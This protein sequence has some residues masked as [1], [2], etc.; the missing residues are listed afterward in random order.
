MRRV[1]KRAAAG[2]VWLVVCGVAGAETWDGGG[3]DNEYSTALNWNNDVI[4]TNSTGDINGAYTVERFADI[5][6]L[7]TFVQGGAILNVTGGTQNDSESGNTIRNFIGFGSKGT[8]NQSGGSYNIGHILIVGGSNS[9]GDGTY[10][11]SGGDLAVSRGG[12]SFMGVSGGSSIE[13][14]VGGGTGLFNI[15]GGSL[16]TRIGVGIGATGTFRVQGSGA[17]IIGIGSNGSLDGDW[18][19]SA[20]GTLSVG[21]DAGGVTKILIDDYQDDGGAY[22]TFESGSLLD[23]DFYSTGSG[24]GTWTVLEVEGTN[25]VDN[26]LAFAPGVDTSVWSFAIDNSGPNGLLTVTSVGESQNPTHV[27]VN[28]IAQLQQYADASNMTV[29]MTPGTY[30]L[31]GPSIRPAPYANYAVFLDLSGANST[32][33]F[34]GVHIKVDTQELDGYGR[35]YGH[36]SGVQVLQISGY[37]VEVDGLTLTMEKVSYDGVDQYGNPRE[38]SADW[39]SQLVRVIASNTTIKNCNFTTGGSYPYGYGDAFGKGNRPNTDGVTDAAWISHSKQSGFL[40]T[41]GASNVTVDNVVLNMRSFGHGFFMQQGAGN[42]LFKDCKA[43]G[44][45]MADSDD[46]IA[47]PEY[48]AWGFATYKEP[49]PADIRISKHEDAFRTYGNSDSANNGYPAD[50]YNVTITNCVA[51]RMRN[52]TP[53]HATGYCRIYD[54]EVYDCEMGLTANS[55]GESTILNCKGNARNGPLIY[56]QYS[57]VQPAIYEVELTGD[58]P[59]HGVK[60]IALISGAGNRITLT[61]SAAPGVYSKEAYLN[62]SQKWREWRHRP[63]YDIDERYAGNYSDYT[64]GNFITNLTDQILVFGENATDNI[65]CVSTGGV[66][67]KGT[68]NE[69]TGETLVSGEIVVE[70]TWSYPPN[71]TNVSWAQYDSGGNLILPTPPYIVFDGIQVVDDAL[72]LGGSPVGDGGTTV[73]NG[74]L[75]IAPGFA[76]HGEEVV[77][78]G[79]GTTG[80]GAL[81]SD[82]SVNN[83]TR[84]NSSSGSITLAGDTSIGVGV[85]GNQ[86]LVGPI[87]GTG[88]LT[89]VGAGQLVMEGGANS[90]SGSLIIAEGGIVARANKVNNDLVIAAGAGLSQNASLALN[91]GA[92]N[93]TLL[94]GT[95]D[96]NSRGDSTALSVHIGLLTG[97]ASGLITSTSSAA[98]QTVHVSGGSFDGMVNGA[99]AL[100][101]NG[102]GTTF[103]LN[104][105]CSHTAGTFV[106]AGRL[107][108]SGMIAGNVEVASGAGIAPG[109]HVGTL[110]TGSNVWNENAAMDIEIDAISNDL[111]VINGSLTLNGTSFQIAV[112]APD[113]GFD[114]GVGQSWKIVD[115]DSVSGFSSE[116]FSV[117][118]TAFAVNNPLGGGSFSVSETGGDL[119]LDFTPVLYTELETWRFRNFGTYSNAGNAADGANPDGD[120]RDNLLEYGTGSDPMVFNSN[121]VSTVGQSNDH[122]TLTFNRIEDPSLTYFVKA[123]TNLASNDWNTIWMST[124]ASNTAGSVTVEDDETISNH[125]KRFLQL[126][127]GY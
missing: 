79:S 13:I 114:A 77:L 51:E 65:G 120:A 101:K 12:N 17:G 108:G 41:E 67:N 102:T 29:T 115:A 15:S 44:D 85:A 113:I 104:G 106:N 16:T 45:T 103:A 19:Q 94:D 24:S 63:A 53:V 60:P 91:Q 112:S 69:Y 90:F 3:A 98:T 9:A 82:G 110:T 105:S 35:A 8:V 87:D 5:N 26:G 97:G 122:L 37:G 42:I 84:L 80:Q 21:I 58:T 95:L 36:D 99:I 54:T 123:G 127:I 117:D 11:L 125:W 66:I 30:W 2:L 92:G 73:S 39:S 118:A 86:L 57:V 74:T 38:Y 10:N 76:L 25:I 72:S 6:V 31:E 43:L 111:L 89:K 7:R 61:S 46:I 119:Y 100:M 32:F 47:H 121:A 124:G 96:V 28:S 55:L 14:G 116:K 126:H 23:V 50:I 27:T 88:N 93:S 64:T 81:Y 78:F 56:F 71:S 33:D 48:Q 52:A 68:G 109:N 22:A 18:N 59:G 34:T 49:I 40:I 1:D 20:G 4:P 62:A 83:Q 70:D 107:G 75:E